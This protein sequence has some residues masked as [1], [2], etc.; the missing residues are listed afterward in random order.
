MIIIQLRYKVLRLRQI[1]WINFFFQVLIEVYRLYRAELSQTSPS[2]ESLLI[3][4]NN[5]FI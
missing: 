3:S 4:F 1:S 2:F 5:F